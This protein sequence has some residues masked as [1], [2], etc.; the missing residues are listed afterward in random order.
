MVTTLACYDRKVERE[1]FGHVLGLVAET[2]AAID[3]IERIACMMK[4]LETVDPKR[5]SKMLA[6]EAK[7]WGNVFMHRRRQLADKVELLCQCPT[8]ADKVS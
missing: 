4:M 3:E 1:F 8:T 5:E 7:R 6:A 2:Q